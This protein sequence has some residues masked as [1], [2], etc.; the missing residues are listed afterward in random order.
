MPS[1]SMLHVL[2]LFFSLEL[3]VQHLSLILMPLNDRENVQGLIM[4]NS[5]SSLH[6]SCG[7][8]LLVISHTLSNC[9]SPAI[10]LLFLY[11]QEICFSFTEGS[12]PPRLHVM[13]RLQEE[14]LQSH[15]CG[16][17]RS[18]SWHILPLLCCVFGSPRYKN[19]ILP[20][21]CLLGTHSHV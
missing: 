21:T 16:R 1:A 7:D 4:F 11:S 8:L 12:S 9:R 5:C 13:M 17:S 10:L 15:K 18:S 19:V 2:S 14:R 3:S 6:S 20:C